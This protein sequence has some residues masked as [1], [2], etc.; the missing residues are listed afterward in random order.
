MC[1][2]LKC[3]YTPITEKKLLP[4]SYYPPQYNGCQ[5][6]CELVA[7]GSKLSWLGSCSKESLALSFIKLDA[8]KW[9]QLFELAQ[10][11]Y[12]VKETCKPTSVHDAVC[13]LRE[14]IKEFVMS[15]C[16]FV[17]EVPTVNCFDD[18]S[19]DMTAMPGSKFFQ[20][21]QRYPQLPAVCDNIE[22]INDSIIAACKMSSSLIRKSHQ[23]ERRKATELLLF[24]ATDTERMF[25]KDKPTSIP[26]AFALKG[27]SICTT[28]ARKL[29]NQVRDK[30]KEQQIPIL[31]KCMDRQWEETRPLTVYEL[32]WD[33]TKKF[34]RMSKDQCIQEID[35]FSSVNVLEQHQMES[36]SIEHLVTYHFGNLEV[37]ISLEENPDADEVQRILSAISY[38][39]PY[40]MRNVLGKFWTV[41][42]CKCPDLWKIDL[43]ISVNSL[44]VLGLER[45]PLDISLKEQQNELDKQIVELQHQLL[46]HAHTEDEIVPESES[47]QNKLQQIPQVLLGSHSHI[48]EEFL[49]SLLCGNKNDRWNSVELDH[50]YDQFP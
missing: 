44:Q 46:T 25:C 20:M 34:S 12:G 29:I 42:K 1:L 5:L 4:V 2:E 17:A 27:R 31:C 43:G 6:M 50:L 22:K 7:T 18:N 37:E 19:M 47:L 40:N 38:C 15:N 13:Y 21:R 33:A 9:Q 26:V 32:Q 24:A 45:G 39:G 10:E 28:T 3:P 35:K 23:L 48:L 11:L 16:Q 41:W 8:T 36:V 49:I 14:D 30:M